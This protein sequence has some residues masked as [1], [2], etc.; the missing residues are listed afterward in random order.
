MT[1]EWYLRAI[2]KLGLNQQEA[3]RLLSVGYRTSRRWVAD[4]SRIPWAV[5]LLLHLMIVKHIPVS[6]ILDVKKRLTREWKDG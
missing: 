3:A 2:A 6:Y 4:E 5:V 1:F